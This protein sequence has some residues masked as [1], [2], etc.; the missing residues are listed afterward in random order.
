MEELFLKPIIVSTNDMDR[1]ERVKKETPV[2]TL[3]TIDLL[4]IFLSPKY[5]NEIKPYLRKIIIDPLQ[6][7]T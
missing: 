6:S 5:L 7:D 2:K 4:I 3:G 1:F